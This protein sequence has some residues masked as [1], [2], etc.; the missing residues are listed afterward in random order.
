MQSGQSDGMLL[1]PSGV[2]ENGFCV[3]GKVIEKP[4]QE[5]DRNGYS[6]EFGSKLSPLCEEKVSLS[7]TNMGKLSSDNQ[8]SPCGD[9]GHGTTTIIECCSPMETLKICEGSKLLQTRL[10]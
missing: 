9:T 3:D 7:M 1:G 8:F 5:S 10:Q 6:V 4:S 2:L